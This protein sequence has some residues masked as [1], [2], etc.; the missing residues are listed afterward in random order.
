MKIERSLNG[1]YKQERK[2]EMWRKSRGE[3]SVLKRSE[4]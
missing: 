3:R 2:T 1:Q 4:G